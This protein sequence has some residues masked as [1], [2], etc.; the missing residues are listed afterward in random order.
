M[1]Y[2]SR[3]TPIKRVN[4]FTGQLLGAADFQAEQDYH[5]AKQRLHNRVLL[6]SGVAQGLQVS[7]GKGD[8][9]GSVVVAPGSAVDRN[10]ELLVLCE[11]GLLAL[12]S[13]RRRRAGLSSLHRAANGRGA[14][15]HHQSRRNS[16]AQPH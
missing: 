13:N 4:Y 10:G 14:G 1:G 7:V 5:R 12:K 15:G 16:S 3:M 8:A 9:A 11:A 2:M 6:G